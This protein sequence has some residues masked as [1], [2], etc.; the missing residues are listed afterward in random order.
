MN[1]RKTAVVLLSGGLDSTTCLG[2]ALKAGFEPV[3][4][5]EQG[6]Y[7]ADDFGLFFKWWQHQLYWIDFRTTYYRLSC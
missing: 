6:F 4:K 2:L 5:G 7:A 3:G 1:E